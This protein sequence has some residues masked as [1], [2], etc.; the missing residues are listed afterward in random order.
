MR[1]YKVDI[2]PKKGVNLQMTTFSGAIKL[3]GIYDQDLRRVESDFTPLYRSYSDLEY[4]IPPEYFSK[5]GSKFKLDSSVVFRVEG[6][7]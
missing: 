4:N 2:D 7:K 3:E 6:V 1:Y 5:H